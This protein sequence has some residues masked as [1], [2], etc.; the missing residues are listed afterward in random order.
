M[1][2]DKNDEK[3][4]ALELLIKNGLKTIQKMVSKIKNEVTLTLSDGKQVYVVPANPEAPE[5]LAGASVFEV[6]EAGLPTTNPVADGSI[7]LDDGRTLVVVAGKVTEVQQKVNPDALKADLAAKEEALRVASAEIAALKAEKESNNLQMKKEFDSI[8]AAFKEFKASVPG[9]RKDKKD[10]DDDK[11]LDYSK[12][13]TA[14]RVR[15]MS[16]ERE[17]MDSERKQSL[18][19]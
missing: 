7:T 10:N 13:S 11:P 8:Q 2:T 3:L 1:N 12:M 17:K 15:A 18:I 14:Q 5:D 9:D 6:D 16:K 4:S 19:Q